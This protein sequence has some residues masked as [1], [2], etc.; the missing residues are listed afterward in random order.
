M[1][2]ETFKLIAVPYKLKRIND[3][4][5][6]KKAYKN[7]LEIYYKKD[8]DQDLLEKILT[9]NKKIIYDYEKDKEIREISH[10]LVKSIIHK[11]LRK[12]DK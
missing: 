11:C 4:D 8:I 9:S 1:I 10:N 7:A 6:R 2:E 12:F 3:I 5:H